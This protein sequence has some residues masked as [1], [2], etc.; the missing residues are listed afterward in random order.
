[1]HV[2][3]VENDVM[4]ADCLADALLDYG[5]V[6][7]GVAATVAEAVALARQHRPDAAILDMH[8][9][10]R[11]RGSDIAH[12]LA[13]SGELGH[14]GILYVTGDPEHVQ[15]EAL[16]GHACL[17]KPYEFATLNTAL[18]I[19]TEIAREGVTSR[20]LPR[21]LRLLDGDPKRPPHVGAQS[22]SAVLE[23]IRLS[24]A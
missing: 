11:E 16:V 3:V 15:Q 8:L 10:R 12:Q 18:D 6:I 5:H 17:H 14:T 19:V 1:M 20:A 22:P 2:L 7:C 23:T 21:G 24:A 13:D 4:L 9:S